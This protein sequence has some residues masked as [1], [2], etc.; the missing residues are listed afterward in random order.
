MANDPLSLAAAALEKFIIDSPAVKRLVKAKNIDGYTSA[1]GTKTND[2]LT[3]SDLPQI[4]LVCRSGPTNLNLASNLAQF[5]LAFDAQVKSGDKRF[6]H[7]L[8]PVVWA[9][10]TACVDAVHNSALTAL[11]WEESRFI[12]DVSLSNIE[13]GFHSV[14]GSEQG[15]SGTTGVCTITLHC[16]FPQTLI[17]AGNQN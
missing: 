7:D 12:K 14:D 16:F 1:R 2:T 15:I 8:L 11:M 3:E 13:T 17:I 10:F 4:R 6:T 5:D 9:L